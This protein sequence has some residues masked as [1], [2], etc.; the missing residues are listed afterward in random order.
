[1][2]LLLAGDALICKLLYCMSAALNLK[3]GI[4]CITK[5]DVICSTHTQTVDKPKTQKKRTLNS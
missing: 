2:L 1:M 3:N 4:H 5:D